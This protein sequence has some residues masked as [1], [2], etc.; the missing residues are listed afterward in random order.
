[1]FTSGL[2]FV[3][4]GSQSITVADTRTMTATG[5][6][7]VSVA[8]AAAATFIVSAPTSATAGNALPVTITAQDAFGNIATGYG[9]T[10]HVTST[11]PRASISPAIFAFASGMDI[12]NVTLY[13]ANI[14][15]TVTVTDTTTSSIT[16]TSNAI[17]VHSGAATHFFVASSSTS[18][19][20]TA[21]KPITVTVVALDSY[22][23]IVTNYAGTVH[24]T[25][26]DAHAVLP[27]NSILTNSGG[28]IFSATLVT[29]GSPAQT[30]TATDSSNS[31]I[32]GTTGAITVTAAAASHFSIVAPASAVSGQPFIFTV[33][34]LDS[35]GNVATGYSG[36]VSFRTEGSATLPAP[37][38]LTNGNGIFTATLKTFGNQT[39]TGI[40]TTN[41][42]ISGTSNVITVP[43]AMTLDITGLPVTVTAGTAFTFTVTA[44]YSNNNTTTAYTGTV[45]FSSTDVLAVL[46]ADYTFTSADQ[47][48]HVFTNIKLATAGLETITASDTAT[49]ITG[50]AATS[51]E[52]GAVSSLTVSAP[53]TVTAGTSISNVTVTAQDSFGN[54]ATAYTDTVHLSSTDPNAVLPGNMTLT[55]GVGLFTVTLQTAGVQTL[56]ATDTV[57]TNV[58]GSSKAITVGPGLATHFALSGYKAAVGKG[59]PL[60]FTVTALDPFGNMAVGY[61]GTVDFRS[62]DYHAQ[63]PIGATLTN[64][65]GGFS[66]TLNTGGIQTVTATDSAN[67]T[68][69]G[70]AVILAVS[71]SGTGTF[72]Q[73]IDR[74]SPA[75]AVIGGGTVIYTVTFNE[76][77][78]GVS[79]ADFQLA[80]GGTVAATLT[81]VTPVNGAIYA[82]T[83]SGISGNGTL[84]LD[85]VDNG[86]IHDLAGDPFSEQNAVP[87]FQTAQTF[88]AG[89]QPISVAL[90]DLT[91]DQIPDIVVA[92]LEG[93]S[94]SVLLGNGNGTFQAQ[95]TIFT[96][97]YPL[98]VAVGD[99]TGN[100][101]PDLVV[102]NGL[103]D[104]VSVLL[105]NGN[106]TFQGQPALATGN[107]PDSV[108]IGDL[109][110]D[111]IP[112]LVVANDGSNTVSVLLGNGDGTFQVQQTFATAND[113]FSVAIGNL[114]GDGKPD[115]AVADLGSNAVSVLFG[116][117]NGTFQTQQ[118]F[119]TGIGPT[120][121]AVSDLNSDGNAD[122]VVANQTS[123]TVSVLLGNG[124][125]TFEPQQTFA[126]TNASSVAVG[127]VNG[128]GIP[129]VIAAGDG[130]VSVLLGNGNG[131]FQAQQTFLAGADSVALGDVNGDGKLDLVTANQ[132]NTVSVLLNSAHGSFAGQV[133]TTNPLPPF[134]QSI[135]RTNPASADTNAS[136]VTFTVTL[137][138]PMT[139]VRLA[140]F[141]VVQS[142]TVIATSTQFA[143]V[144]SSV[145][146]VTVSG[147]TG[148]GTIG[149][150]CVS[151]IGQV[152]TLDTIR[153]MCSRSTAP[154]H[155][156]RSPTPPASASRLLSVRR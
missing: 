51:V 86:S 102:A 53:N 36:T 23:N 80:L 153:L 7:T 10:V 35:Y 14:P 45:H 83:V 76:A 107:S 156:A 150:N 38:T 12:F 140:D 22:G 109:T 8:A 108:A 34:A 106:G 133:Y 70:S 120:S 121:V 39:I 117:G 56:T 90:V 134:V 50:S 18:G 104:T 11:D 131:S 101:L 25:S 148:N 19:T 136:S 155:P 88:A 146:T 85:L 87:N 135:T 151:S 154:P 149:L 99:L 26:T 113:P 5:S 48:V 128:D 13:T 73:S 52:A 28:G 29:V 98:S 40:D 55:N 103:S 33:E 2:E 64:G 116:N 143:Q 84:G 111:G 15:Q 47:G 89:N 139:G 97:I 100:G 119:A 152:F 65:V 44:A 17:T 114:N 58:T 62:S 91:G 144:S 9:G 142:G 24:F 147:I 82:V 96:G 3:T 112:D 126:S 118:T 1:M 78:T 54:T 57:A 42:G 81:Q 94:V 129:D 125:G 27:A 127:D 75:A 6:A 132:G 110:G 41:S 66:A 16:G 46:P 69:T 4:A 68:I 63:L 124:N 43:A 138:Q 49:A 130:I 30:I 60:D 123:N 61:V 21:G 122:L 95:Q 59:F 71:S 74:T 141:Q 115:L 93:N 137:S 67:A 72:V 37:S 79:A 105:G 92:N 77:V 32:T 145:Y 20:A 31:S